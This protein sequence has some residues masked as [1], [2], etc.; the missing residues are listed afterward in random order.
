MSWKFYIIAACVSLVFPACG[1]S[2]SS[3]D[4]PVEEQGAV[5]LGG[6]APA[7]GSATLNAGAGGAAASNA[8]DAAETGS[9]APRPYLS[10]VRRRTLPDNA[11]RP[12]IAD[13]I[14]YDFKDDAEINLTNGSDE[15]DC[16]SRL[17]SVNP[18]LTW[19]AWL[20]P[21]RNK[22][23]VAPID[24][25]N[26]VIKSDEENVRVV[27][28]DVDRVQFMTFKPDGASEGTELLVYT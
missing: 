21:D 20:D 6:P 3:S 12:V 10:F 22:L 17:C 16:I 7:G 25:D 27:S 15:V 5:N 28:E 18:E 8:N 2:S 24:F 13:I 4:E 23:K 1:S 9:R 26:D 14:V 19:V 11:E